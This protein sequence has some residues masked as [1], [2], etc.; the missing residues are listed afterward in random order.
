MSRV[1]IR[2]RLTLGFAAAMAVV[3]AAV[4]IF[5]YHRVANELLGTVDQELVGQA[6]EATRSRIVDVDTEG[7][8]TYAQ[9]FG[10]TG[11]LRYSEPRQLRR[12]V[13]RQIVARTLASGQVWLNKPLPGQTGEWRL[14]AEPLQSGNGIVVLARSLGPRDESLAHLRH[15]LLIF[16]PLALL[17]ASLG[18]Y[19]LAAGAL[20]PVELLRRRAGA[21]TP[22]EPS[23]PPLPPSG[24]KVSLTSQT[25]NEMPF[26]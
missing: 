17:A 21:V 7:G 13:G 15:E 20:H 26:A 16:L 8:R 24:D 25:L 2:V 14:L 23:K 1:P 19:A 11:Q 5:V 6:R 9:R 3:L 22:G 10:L 12:L 4:G 18:G